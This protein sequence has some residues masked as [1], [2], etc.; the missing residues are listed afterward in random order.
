MTG[1]EERIAIAETK[2][3]VLEETL[4]TANEKL[5]ILIENMNKMKGFWAGA[6]AAGTALGAA[7]S[8]LISYLFHLK[9]GG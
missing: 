3:E 6:V 2:I 5:D 8:A 9:F 7:L 1:N 4:H